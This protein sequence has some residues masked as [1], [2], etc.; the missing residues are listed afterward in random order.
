MFEEDSGVKRMKGR[1]LD[2][3]NVIAENVDVVLYESPPSSRIKSWQGSFELTY[4]V[5]IELSKSYKLILED[6][7][8]GEILVSNIHASSETKSR[9][10]GFTGSGPLQ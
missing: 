5:T 9:S 7:R 6:R 1:V 8:S 10:I 3:N 2:V 4:D